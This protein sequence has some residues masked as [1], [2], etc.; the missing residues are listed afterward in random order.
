[1]KY[2]SAHDFSAYASIK[3]RE[4]FERVAP[5]VHVLPNRGAHASGFEARVSEIMQWEGVNANVRN[6]T[7]EACHGG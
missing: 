2:G 5:R 3:V 1:M 4:V 6:G 7:T